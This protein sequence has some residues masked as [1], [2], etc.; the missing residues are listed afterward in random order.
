VLSSPLPW[1]DY[2]P[3]PEFGLKFP[4]RDLATPDL[5]KLVN[6]LFDGDFSTFSFEGYLAADRGLSLLFSVLI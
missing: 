5:I 1:V 3:L 4:L 2:S 6:E